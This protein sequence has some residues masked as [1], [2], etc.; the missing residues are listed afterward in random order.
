MKNIFSNK[1][2]IILAAAIIGIIAAVLQ[3]YGNPPNMGFCMAC[4]ERDIA[5][6]IGFHNAAVVKYIRPEIIGIVI[7]ALVISLFSGEFKPRGGSSAIIRFF[8]GVFAMIGALVFLGCPWRAFLRLAGGDLNAILGILGLAAGVGIGAYFLKKGFS[9]GRSRPAENKASGYIMPIFMVALLLL[10]IFEFSKLGFS[11]KGPGA[12]H[13][14]LLLSLGAGLLVGILAQRSRFCTMGSIR[15]IF[16]VKN[17]HLFYGVIAFTIAAFAMNM[18][19]DQFTPGF[20]QQPIAHNLHIWNFLGMV[21]SGLAFVLA[22]GCPGRQLVLTGE[23]NT[24]S[25]MF[26][27]GMLAGAGLAHNFG[28]AS[29]P[30]GIGPFGDYATII[31]IAF[32][33]VIG[34]I[35]IKRNKV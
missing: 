10:L 30:K 16:I 3:F 35:M 14:P 32:C 12:M 28:L 26:V 11:Q 1:W 27:M 25:G 17:F 13:A 33:L 18:I 4:F 34:I 9:L 19:L 23:G 20:E 24:D 8:L 6:A 2:G 15:D 21:L 31:G 7:G 29:S 22:G 5:G